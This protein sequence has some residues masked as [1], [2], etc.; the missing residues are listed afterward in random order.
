MPA[1]GAIKLVDANVWLALAFSDHQ[2]HRRAKEW[3]DSQSKVRARF[4]G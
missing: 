4:A 3:F 2:H 1:S